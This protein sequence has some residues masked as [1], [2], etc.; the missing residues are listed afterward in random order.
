MHRFEADALQNR[1]HGRTR[2]EDWPIENLAAARAAGYELPDYMLELEPTVG[3]DPDAYWIEPAP[4]TRLIEEGDTLTVGSRQFIVLHLPGHTRGGVGLFEEE[5][6]VLFSG[7][8][9][10]DGPLVDGLP[11][12]NVADFVKSITRIRN[13]SVSAAHGGHGDSL[14]GR[15]TIELAD[16]YLHS[17]GVSA[18]PAN[19]FGSV[20]T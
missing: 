1:V 2:P 12:S 18:A 13:L 9:L 8:V 11:E 19:Q 17:K 3:F 5:T 7:D 16:R 6:G 15:R 14:S 20:K 4:A 10:Y